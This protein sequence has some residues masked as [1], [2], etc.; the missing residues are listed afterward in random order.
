M[1]KIGE[2]EMFCRLRHFIVK[3]ILYRCRQSLADLYNRF[4]DHVTRSEKQRILW[5]VE[6]INE[7][8]VDWE[9]VSRY[10]CE[11]RRRICQGQK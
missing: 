1:R 2:Y 11:K 3:G 4:P 7:V 6:S 9:K 5:A 8:L 10:V